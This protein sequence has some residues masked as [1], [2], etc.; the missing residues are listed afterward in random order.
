MTKKKKMK[1]RPKK[2]STKLSIIGTLDD[3]LKA[4]TKPSKKKK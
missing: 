4:S 2:Y 1:K 3:V